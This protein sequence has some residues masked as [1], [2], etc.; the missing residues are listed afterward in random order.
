MTVPDLYTDDEARTLKPKRNY[1]EWNLQRTIAAFLSK[2]LP[3]TAYWTSI[4]IG[5][6]GG[7]RG[8][9]LRKAR[10]VKPG[11]ADIMVA[12]R[13]ISH[14]VTLWLEVKAGTQLSEAQKLFRDQ[15]TSNGHRWALVRSP[16][17]VEA[18]CLDARI[19]LRAN[20]GEIRQRIDEQNERLPVKRK[21]VA[22]KAGTPSNSMSLAQYRRLNERGLV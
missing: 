7:L 14:N 3:E 9:Q 1:G 17:D 22:R 12:W 16:E 4:D 10:G 15:I 21:R 8:G 2:A 18:A 19:P 6:A 11:I 13:G 20:L 5:S